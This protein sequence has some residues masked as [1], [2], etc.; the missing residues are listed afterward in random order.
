MGF[1]CYMTQP[2]Q[3]SG[4]W[5]NEVEIIDQNDG[6]KG[7]KITSSFEGGRG[8]ITQHKKTETGLSLKEA[9]VSY[10][11]QASGLQCF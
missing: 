5:H 6:K 3:G 8:I 10:L 11:P 4:R 7:E 1:G 9:F 2:G